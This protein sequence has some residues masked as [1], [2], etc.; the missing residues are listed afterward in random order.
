MRK[1]EKFQS[2]LSFPVWTDDREQRDEVDRDLLVRNLWCV[3]NSQWHC[4]PRLSIRLSIKVKLSFF[5]SSLQ[6]SDRNPHRGVWWINR[7]NPSS[8]AIQSF[9]ELFAM[10]WIKS[11]HKQLGYYSIE[12][13]FGQ[14]RSFA[15]LGER[16]N[17]SVDDE[18]EKSETWWRKQTAQSRWGARAWL[19]RWEYLL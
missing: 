4:Y 5:S 1:T 18:A 16:V 12:F 6:K 7:L 3:L 14:Q 19:E 8:S 11:F 2:T 15:G 9:S 17:E 10:R 13:V